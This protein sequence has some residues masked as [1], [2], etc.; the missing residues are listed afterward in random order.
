MSGAGMSSFGPMIGRSSE[1][2]R[3]VSRSSSPPER[4]RGV[5]ADAALRAAVRQAQER[6][7]P[8]HPHGERGALAERDLGVVADA[9]LRRAHDARVLDAVAGEHDALARVHADRH[10]D[11]RGALRKAEALGDVVRDVG[12]RDRLVELRDRHPVQRRVP[13]ELGM[14]KR[15]RGARHGGPSVDASPSSRSCP[16]SGAPGQLYHSRTRWIVPHAGGGTR[17]RTSPLGTPAFKAGA[18]HPFR[19]PGGPSVRRSV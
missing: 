6:A 17:T 15:F 9:A 1:V 4:V 12:D 16:R 10:R 3:R 19:H 7:L 11:H 2:N 5:A 14:G 13:L 8:R 18:S